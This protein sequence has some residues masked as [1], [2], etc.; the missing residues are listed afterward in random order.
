MNLL[1]SANCLFFSVLAVVL[2]SASVS[3]QTYS[4]PFAEKQPAWVFPLWFTNGDGQKD[5]I[6]LAYDPE[7]SSATEDSLFGEYSIEP[8]ESAFYIRIGPN[9][10]VLATVDLT[11]ATDL[12]GY[13]IAYPFT[14][15]YDAKL[16]YSDSLPGFPSNEVPKVW[17][18]LTGEGI[19]DGCPNIDFDGYQVILVDTVID[20]YP[21][22]TFVEPHCLRD[23]LVIV[24]GEATMAI[25]LKE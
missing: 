23:S 21:G 20:G 15:T 4:I 1:K 19:V 18:L 10:R 11:Y 6:Y 9:W 8:D 17:A 14:I 12:L 2:L 3:G 16:L 22:S 7:A 13:N 24:E 25:G 5:T